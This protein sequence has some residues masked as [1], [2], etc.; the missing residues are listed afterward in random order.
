LPTATYLIVEIGGNG[1]FYA[2]SRSASPQIVIDESLAKSLNVLVSVV[3]A[4]NT[5]QQ[6][7]YNQ[8]EIEIN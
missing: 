8:Y 7:L 3:E 4:K 2:Y 6:P 5:G 1:F